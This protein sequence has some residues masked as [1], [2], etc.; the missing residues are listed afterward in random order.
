MD[1][2]PNANNYDYYEGNAVKILQAIIGT[3]QNQI[4]L[5]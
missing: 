3:I 1:N 4:T 5:K 2:T